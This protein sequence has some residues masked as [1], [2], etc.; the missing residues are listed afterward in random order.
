[1]R[2]WA[3]ATQ[4]LPGSRG[5]GRHAACL[6]PHP[7]ENA[8]QGTWGEAEVSAVLPEGVRAAPAVAHE[9]PAW[10]Q[11]AQLQEACSFPPPS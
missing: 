10:Q 6:P 7:R 8:Q 9:P 2:L 3:V 1:M 4:L 5:Q 11:A